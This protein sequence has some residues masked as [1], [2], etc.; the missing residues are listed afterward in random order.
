MMMG[1]HHD[2]GGVMSIS[3]LTNLD[4]WSNGTSDWN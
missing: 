3:E 4:Q 1:G 2:V